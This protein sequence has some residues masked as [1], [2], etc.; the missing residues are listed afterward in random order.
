M[1]IAYIILALSTVCGCASHLE[2]KISVRAELSEYALDGTHVS[3]ENEPCLWFDSVTFE[4]LSPSKWQGANLTID[5]SR[6]PTNSPL[7][8]V[9]TIYDFK[10]E[11]KYLMGETPMDDGSFVEHIIG[12]DIFDQMKHIK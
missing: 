6:Q 10:I 12:E 2:R 3:I 7:R 11:A 8:K 5:C 1:K 4:I 9:G